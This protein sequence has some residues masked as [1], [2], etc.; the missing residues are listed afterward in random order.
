MHE[1][2]SRQAGDNDRLPTVIFYLNSSE[3]LV[4]MFVLRKNRKRL[5][6]IHNR[7]KLLVDQTYCMCTLLVFQH[8]CQICYDNLPA[9]FASY[10]WQSWW[11]HFSNFFKTFKLSPPKQ[12]LTQSKLPSTLITFPLKYSKLLSNVRFIR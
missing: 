8:I 12:A 10:S 2:Q 11:F 4:P 9:C 7:L 3:L 1:N 5:K 6:F